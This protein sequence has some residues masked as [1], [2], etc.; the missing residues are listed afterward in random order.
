M[1]DSLSMKEHWDD[2]VSLFSVLA[3]IVKR[4]DDDGLEM[5]FTVSLGVEKFR[6]T[7]PAV[8]HLKSMRPSTYSNIN[9][10]LERI[11]RKYQT[12][13]N[14]QRERRGIFWSRAKTI[15]PL[16]LYVFTD[17]AWHG[18]DAVAP[19]EAMIEKQRQLGLPKEQVGIQFIRFGNDKVG[20]E[21]LQFLDSGLRKKYG[22]RWYVQDLSPIHG[23]S[24]NIDT[25]LGSRDI[26]DTE[27]F[28][29]GNLW[30]MLLGAVFD[31]FDDDPD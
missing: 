31:W 24:I 25:A 15:K 23:S 14:H 9:I 11:L 30:K 8:A 27:P 26:V 20:M 18:C 5:Y 4:L 16:S 22:K 28:L 10:R 12:N 1:D 21:R 6:D 7:T 3:Y 29:N 17:G 13:L 19:V 2:V